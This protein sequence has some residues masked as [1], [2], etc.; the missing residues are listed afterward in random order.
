MVE[1]RGGEVKVR[2]WGRSRVVGVGEVV[3]GWGWEWGVGV[4]VEREPEVKVKE[5]EEE[6]NKK[7]M[8]EGKQDTIRN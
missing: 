1:V 7:G 8:K 2:G 3:R 5:E 6:T 4:E